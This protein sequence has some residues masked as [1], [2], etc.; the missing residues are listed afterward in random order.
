[1]TCRVRLFGT[2]GEE[3][4]DLDSWFAHAPPEK[5][6]VQW[7]DGYSAKEQAKAWLRTGAPAVPDELWEALAEIPLGEVEEVF[8]RPEHRTRLDDYGRE[9]QHDLFACAR[10]QGSTRFVVGVEAKACEHFD[11]I[12]ADRAA[13]GPP[14][15]KRARCNL[16]SCALFGRP[17]FDEASGEILDDSLA[18][19]GYQLWTAAVGTI[20]EAQRREVDDAVLIVQQFV[21]R[22]VDGVRN[23]DRRDWATALLSNAATLDAF[24]AAVRDA[25]ATSRDTAFVEAG[26][27]LHVVKAVDA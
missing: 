27:R 1:M 10:H 2:Y 17:V 6:A 19:H 5:G 22:A 14:S 24:S 7:R 26:T 3:I 16:L 20:I 13:A 12:V 25:G 4:L 8:G 15:N 23:D 18:S 21:P 9:R 11:G